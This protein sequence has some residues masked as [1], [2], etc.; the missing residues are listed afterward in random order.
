M[1]ID[2]SEHKSRSQ[3]RES[4]AVYV[5]RYC[6]KCYDKTCPYWDRISKAEDIMIEEVS[7]LV[8]NLI[9]DKLGVNPYENNYGRFNTYAGPIIK[10][11][12]YDGIL[13]HELS[14][15]GRK[16][17][18][19]AGDQNLKDLFEKEQRRLTLEGNIVNT[20]PIFFHDNEHHSKDWIESGKLDMYRKVRFEQIM[21]S[22]EIY[23]INR[24][25]LSVDEETEREIKIADIFSIPVSFMDAN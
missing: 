5:C 4:D 7:T 22:D 2:L 18:T 20:R 10:C 24:K 12:Q 25:G 15:Y 13:I 1:G 3:Q 17:I 8:K 16:I 14:G 6:N 21:H 19:L 9:T 11:D 23:V